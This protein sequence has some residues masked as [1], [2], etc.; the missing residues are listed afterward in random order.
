[1]NEE[2]PKN[3]STKAII[4]SILVAVVLAAGGYFFLSR[5]NSN[6]DSDKTV[7]ISEGNPAAKS[8]T[9]GNPKKSAHYENNVP[10]H[11][12]VLA[13]APIN[14]VI[15]FNFDLAANSNISIQMGSKEY[16]TGETIIDSGKLAMRRKM[17]PASP[18]GLYAVFYRACWA[19]G[20]CH[21]GNFQFA[22]DKKR[23]EKFSD[24][25]GKAEITIALE[26]FK[27]DPKEVRISRGT[28]VT[29]VNK[30]SA[31][32]TVNTDN[33]PEHTYY[34]AQNSRDLKQG[35]S[36]AVTFGEPGIFPYHCTPHAKIM[37]GTILV[38]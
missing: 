13:G 21:E 25:R 23:A 30:D 24:M 8:V 2:A 5:Q 38:E 6:K 9:F 22:I 19:D 37:T 27:F 15:D 26:N 11:A 3:K 18:D 7:V 14:V 1:M 35:E 33:H 12:A 34:L 10:N 31:A 4:I 32:H 28:K 16:G 29:W 36:Y 20:S 17:D